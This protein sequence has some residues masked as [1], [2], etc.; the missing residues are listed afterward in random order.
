MK[1]L[2]FL[3]LVLL[4]FSAFS[5]ER[6][7]GLTRDSLVKFHAKNFVTEVSNDTALVVKLKQ[8]GIDWRYFKF[9]KTGTC[10]LAAK[11]VPFYDDFTNLEKKLKAKKYKSGGEAEYN[12]VVSK[13]KGSVYTNGKETYILMYGAINPNMSAT[14]RGVIYY[15]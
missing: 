12:F 7:L 13:V 8:G 4:S 2:L 15:K 1:N 11:E 6:Y 9:D 5:Q 10:V 14:T 3:F